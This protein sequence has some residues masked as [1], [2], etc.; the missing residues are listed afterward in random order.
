MDLSVSQKLQRSQHWHED[1]SVYIQVGGKIT[2]LKKLKLNIQLIQAEDTIFFV[3]RGILVQKSDIFQNMFSMPTGE[4][5]Q[6]QGSSVTDPIRLPVTSKELDDLFS[7]IYK[8]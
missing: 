1:G 3:H 2:I 7:W 5:K 4:S 8:T 6:P